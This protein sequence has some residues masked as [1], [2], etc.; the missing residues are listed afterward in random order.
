M[1]SDSDGALMHTAHTTIANAGD[2]GITDFAKYND[3]ELEDLP[4][5]PK[6]ARILLQVQ[7]HKSV[8]LEEVLALQEGTLEPVWARMEAT[9][10]SALVT[11]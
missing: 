11:A 8:K 4:E 9:V 7:L 2:A 5:L 10:R 6:S 3:S 1:K